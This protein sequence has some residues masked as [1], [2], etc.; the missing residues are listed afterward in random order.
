MY[1]MSK[2][3]LYIGVPDQKLLI[4]E[5]MMNRVWRPLPQMINSVVAISMEG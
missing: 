1:T 4:E 2:K 5:N 3:H